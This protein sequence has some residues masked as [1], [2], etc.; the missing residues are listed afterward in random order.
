MHPQESVRL[1]FRWEETQDDVASDMKSYTSAPE[2][3]M[4]KLCRLVLEAK[5]ATCC[6]APIRQETHASW[7]LHGGDDQSKGDID[8]L[9]RPGQR[10]LRP[11]LIH[12]ITATYTGKTWF[13]PMVVG[14]S[15]SMTEAM[16]GSSVASSP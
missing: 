1:G 15:M 3:H 16:A 2:R 11:R 13:S 8:G 6:P 12:V 4:M 5:L 14:D 10:R 7:E 9:A